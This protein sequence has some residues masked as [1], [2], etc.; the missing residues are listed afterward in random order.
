MSPVSADV[1]VSLNL[2]VLR[3]GQHESEPVVY[4]LQYMLN[5]VSGTNE[6]D[7]DGIFGP[8]TEAAVKLFQGNEGL[9]ADGIVGRQTWTALLIRFL[10]FSPPD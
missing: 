3:K 6:L 7:I 10:T 2:P 9:S 5:Y 1:Q 4:Q 8:K